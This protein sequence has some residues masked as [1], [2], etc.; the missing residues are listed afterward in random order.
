MV[1]DGQRAQRVS[2]CG[3]RGGNPTYR[4]LTEQR[5]RPLST[6]S[7]LRPALARTGARVAGMFRRG[8]LYLVRS[9]L[10]RRTTATGGQRSP[11]NLRMKLYHVRWVCHGWSVLRTTMP[12]ASAGRQASTR[13][14]RRTVP[15]GFHSHSTT[16][17]VSGMGW[18]VALTVTQ[19]LSPSV[20]VHSLTMP[21]PSWSS[22]CDELDSRV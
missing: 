5:H 2:G 7:R 3:V 13:M 16:R 1:Q 14:S 8:C 15:S 19:L 9:R 10:E 11:S 18:P 22:V 4:V 12:S 21:S 6:C 20:E 17:N